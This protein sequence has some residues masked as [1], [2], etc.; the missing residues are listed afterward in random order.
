MFTQE[1][2]ITVLYDKY[3]KIVIYDN[4]LILYLHI[5]VVND[6]FRVIL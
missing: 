6:A 2:N 5:M 1:G 4:N 3:L